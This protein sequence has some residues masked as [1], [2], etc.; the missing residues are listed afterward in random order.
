MISKKLNIEKAIAE[1]RPGAI[2][3]VGGFGNPGTPFA[4]IEELL[5]QGQSELTLIKNDA[6]EPS[7][8]ISR[9][10]EN[11]QVARLI[12]S[13]IGLNRIAIE[14]MNSGE[15]DVEFVPQG[16]LAERIRVG[17]AGIYGFLS[18]IGI[19]TEITSPSDVLHLHGRRFRVETALTA[20]VALIHAARADEIGNLTYRAA[21]R[22]FNP[23]MAMAAGYV[24]AEAGAI[25]A[26][27]AIG[28]DL[29][30][31]PAAFVS[32]VVEVS[33]EPTRAATG[34]EPQE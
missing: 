3:M 8:G 32:A 20:D 26:I 7:I 18:D 9:L 33:N 34:D 11:N 14:K 6:N 30:H 23:L 31:T 25:E 27:G 1:I 29:V 24:I 16:I 2:I 12:T 4:L 19:D 17:G 15:L 5:K 22:N 10:I 21:A 13:H 28:P